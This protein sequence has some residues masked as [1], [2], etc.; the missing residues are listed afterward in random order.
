MQMATYSNILN[1]VFNLM[2]NLV[3]FNYHIHYMII[4]ASAFYFFS[5]CLRVDD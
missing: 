3:K 5:F 4:L 2:M 1:F